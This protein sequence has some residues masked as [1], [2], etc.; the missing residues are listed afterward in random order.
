MIE[1]ERFASPR[2]DWEPPSVPRTRIVVGFDVRRPFCGVNSA[3]TGA[4]TRSFASEIP[5]EN[6]R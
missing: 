6:D 5:R 1:S 3:S 4:G 2:P